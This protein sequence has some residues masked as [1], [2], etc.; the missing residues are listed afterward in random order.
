MFFL[1]TSM[2]LAQQGEDARPLLRQVVDAARNVKSWRAEVTNSTEL[3]AEGILQSK[4]EG[5]FRDVGQRTG[6]SRRETTFAG[7]PMLVVCDGFSTWVQMPTLKRY[8]K[9]PGTSAACAPS[10]S[11]LQAPLAVFQSAVITGRDTV[12]F[13]EIST[14]C[15]VVRI[16]YSLR[17]WWVPSQSDPTTGTSEP[18]TGTQTLC[19]DRARSLI[20]RDTIEVKVAPN[21]SFPK[22]L[23]SKATTTYSRIERDPVLSPDLFKFEPPADNMLV[24]APVAGAPAGSSSAPRVPPNPLPPGVYRA[25]NGVTVPTLIS[26]VEPTYTQEARAAKI[27]GTVVLYIEVDPEGVPQNIRVLRSLE[28][29]LDENAIYAVS[30]WRFRPGTKDGNPVTVAAQVEVNFRLLQGPPPGMML[31]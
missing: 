12:L 20:L 5:T 25:G 23:Q 4:T 26:K 28:P 30:Q 9:T 17:R 3:K 31:P 22:G 6:L 1:F 16:G 10:F 14:P 24:A 8:Q 19:V 18:G 2:A 11:Q 21:P 13:E 29:G 27:N 15:E 7:I